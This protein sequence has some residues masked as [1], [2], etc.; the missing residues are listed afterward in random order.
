MNTNQ[1]LIC[2]G[3]RCVVTKKYDETSVSQ[4]QELE[5][6]VTSDPS[7][8]TEPMQCAHIFSESTNYKIEPGS[9]K[10]CPPFNYFAFCLTNNDYLCLAGLCCLDVGGHGA[11]WV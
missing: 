7:A 4:I 6:R 5:E 1:A 2:D 11:L 10:V 3:Y 8:G 9:D